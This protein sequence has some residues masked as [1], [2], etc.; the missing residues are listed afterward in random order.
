MY[1]EDTS[2]VFVGNKRDEHRF[3]SISSL[4]KGSE[5]SIED[6]LGPISGGGHTTFMQFIVLLISCLVVFSPSGQ[7]IS[8]TTVQQLTN[9]KQSDIARKYQI[10]DTILTKPVVKLLQ[11]NLF[12]E[13]KSYTNG[14]ITFF[15]LSVTPNLFS[16]LSINLFSSIFVLEF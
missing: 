2:Q 9:Q 6:R 3:T 5:A 14:I 7:F 11:N 10:S 12:K 16:L 1:Q 13:I 15:K 4:R 8:K